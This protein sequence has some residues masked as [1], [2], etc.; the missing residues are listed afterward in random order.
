[1][2]VQV[3]FSSLGAV[4]QGEASGS[5][6]G[7]LTSMFCSSQPSRLWGLFH[8]FALSV[9][10]SPPEPRPTMILWGPFLLAGVS[11][12]L[13]HLLLHGPQRTL[14]SPAAGPCPSRGE[15]R[16]A[17]GSLAPIP[18]F[19]GKGGRGASSPCARLHVGLSLPVTSTISDGKFSFFSPF[20][21][22]SWRSSQPLSAAECR[23]ACDC[24]LNGGICWGS[25][26]SL[27]P[28]PL[29]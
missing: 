15:H 9:V 29:L 3:F 18:G 16:A 13:P 27:V 11:T 19:T 17:S 5:G 24:S 8:L 1:M 28:R 6:A 2:S 14:L 23:S 20:F 21:S 12:A 10:S 22:F 4:G 26:S 25:K 7:R